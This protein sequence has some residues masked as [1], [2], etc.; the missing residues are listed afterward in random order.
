MNK[1]EIDQIAQLLLED[2]SR[3]AELLW[4]VSQ[5]V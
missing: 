1:D 3:M 5:G 4:K 2:E